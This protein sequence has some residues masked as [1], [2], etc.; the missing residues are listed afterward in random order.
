MFFWRKAKAFT[1]FDVPIFTY[2][3]GFIHSVITT[4]LIF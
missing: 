3:K 1:N 2:P 4:I